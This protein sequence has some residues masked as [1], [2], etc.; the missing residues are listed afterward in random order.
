MDEVA[1][2]EP[3][4]RISKDESD[5]D[6]ITM[7]TSVLSKPSSELVLEMEIIMSLEPLTAGCDGR[8][9]VVTLLRAITGLLACE[10]LAG[11]LPELDGAA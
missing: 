11:T 2:G 10:A 7:L 1:R 3:P 5:E 8:Q 4:F 6:G 9:V